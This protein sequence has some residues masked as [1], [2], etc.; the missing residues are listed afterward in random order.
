MF[1]GSWGRILEVDVEKRIT[2]VVE[3]PED[4]FNKFL[5]GR[6]LGVYLY[7]QYAR[8]IDSQ[9]LSEANPIIISTGPLTGTAAPTAGRAAMTS[10]SPLTKTIFTSNSGGAFGALLKFTGYDAIVILGKS[11]KPLYI[12]ISDKEIRLE[13]AA[14]LWGKSTTETTEK[15]KSKYSKTSSVI[16]IGQAGEK[17][18]L[19]ASV[20]SDG[21]RGFGRGGLGAVWGYKNIKALVVNG[22]KKPLIKDKNKL[23]NVV[24]EANR[25]IKQNPVTSKALPEL[26]SSFM[27]DVVYFDRALP[28]KNFSTNLFS[29]IAR[30]GSA[31]LKEEIFERST[32]CWGCPISCGRISHDSKGKISEGPEFETIWALGPNLGIG[33]LPFIQ[34]VNR[35]ANEY[36]LDTISLGGV[37]A[38]AME[39]TEKGVW[40]FGIRFG[41]KDKIVNLIDKIVE[42]KGIGEYLK[43]GTANLAQKI[44]KEAEYFAINVK[45]MELP[46][47]D[48]RIIKGM[49]VGYA[50]SNRGGCHLHGGYSAGSEIFGLPRRIDPGMQIGKGTLVAKRQNDSAA[51]DSLIICRFSSMAVSLENWSR[52]LTAVT[53]KHYS[54]RVLSQIGERI[55]NLE[56]IINLKM[57]FSRKDDSL[58]PK[59][60][61][62]YLGEEKIELDVMLNEYYEFRGWDKDGIP[63]KEKI[64]E[65]GLEDIL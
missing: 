5:G 61:K 20:I 32:A 57:G 60:L 24:Y 53:G 21:A 37:I 65:L 6:G 49:A 29:E 11:E 1:Y 59:L 15:L 56:R 28:V 3:L 7:T 44:G 9:P 4:I 62:E 48:P 26:G 54:A 40:D 63:T 14:A 50:T 35:L 8:P 10:R 46:A 19:Y 38:F 58:P 2:K 17:Q 16:S 27:L 43:I 47:Y 25:S 42:N 36:G 22:F 12:Y 64:I 52:I 41:E 31:V 13:N 45:G 18:V 30:V 34:E 55:H 23:K 39:A 33:D 51:E